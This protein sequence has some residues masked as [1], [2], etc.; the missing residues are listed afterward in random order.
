MNQAEMWHAVTTRNRSYDGKFF[1]GVRTTGIFCRPS[2]F[3]RNPK[4]ENTVFFETRQQ[5]EEAGFRPCKRCRPDL[6]LFDPTGDV[7]AKA[8]EAIDHYYSDSEALEL[9]LMSLGVT[10]R[11]LT[12]LFE[13]RY[14]MPVKTYLDLVRLKRAR[15]LLEQGGTVTDAALLVGFETPSAFSTFFRKATGM[16]PTDFVKQHKTAEHT[17]CMETP[18]GNLVI[19]GNEVGITAIRF[20]KPDERKNNESVQGG[21]LKDAVGQLKEY[22][23]GERKTFDI[24]LDLRG[25]LFQKKVWEALR[26]IPYGER[27]SYHE[28][29][30]RIG[31]PK[32][33]RAVGLANNKNPILI[34]IP[35]H[36]VV[37]KSGELVGYAGGIERKEYLLHLEASRSKQWSER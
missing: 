28:V 10:R 36:R 34:V 27:C 20:S 31:N 33:S 5:A 37:G 6:L 13:Q 30:Q 11:H 23:D 16:T 12:R 18:I 19:S 26:Q 4:K 14:D 3:S 8:K 35:C 9:A 29:A 7:T 22:F 21:Y 17:C 15:V 1:Y 32:A 24:P 2:C 25:T